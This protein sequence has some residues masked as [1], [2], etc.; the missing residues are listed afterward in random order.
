MPLVFGTL[1]AAFYAL[2]LAVPLAICGAIYTAH[3]MAPT[4]RRKSEARNRIDGGVARTV[5][6]G[7]PDRVVLRLS[8]RKTCQASLR[9]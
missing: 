9:C 6:L 5:I 3:F 4:V 7:F 8:W 2:L 1:K